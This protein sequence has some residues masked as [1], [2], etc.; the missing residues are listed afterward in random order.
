MKQNNQQINR[1]RNRGGVY[2]S[3]NKD[4][5]NGGNDAQKNL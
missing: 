1:W 5:N 4:Q 2:G 3:T